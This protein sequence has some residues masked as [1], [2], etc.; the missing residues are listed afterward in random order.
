M[1]PR[2]VTQRRLLKRVRGLL[3][4]KDDGYVLILGMLVMFVML[5]MGGALLLQVQRNQQHVQRDRAYTQSLAVAEAGLNQYLW[6][7]ASGTSSEVN[8]FAIPGASAANPHKMSF[9][10][11][12]PYDGTVKGEYA[13]EITPPSASEPN[14]TVKVTGISNQ[15]VEQSRT[16]SAH[17]GRPAFSEYVLLADEQVRIGGPLNRKWY[18]KTH[19]NTGVCM[20]TEN[21]NDIISSART[22]YTYTQGGTYP[23][24]PGVWSNHGFGLTT[25]VPASSPSRNLWMWPVPKVDF[26]TVT[27]DFVKLNDLAQGTGVNIPYSTSAPHDGRQGW[28]IKLMPGEHYQIRQVTGEHED[29]N[30]SD[31]NDVGGYLTLNNGV[32]PH[33]VSNGTYDYP[34]D[35]VIFVHDNVWVEGEPHL[36][37]RITIA[38]SGQ[39]NPTG[40]TAAT[41][42]HII[43]DITYKEIDGTVVVGLIAQN[44]IEI[45]AYAPYRKGT[46]PQIGTVDMEINAAV[47]A[48]QGKEYTR[49]GEIGGPLRD[50]L[51]IYGSVS[52]FQTPYKYRSSG[53]GVGGFQNGSN[54]Y[55][56][57]LLHNPPPYFPTTGTYQIL[58]WQELSSSMAVEP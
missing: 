43:S 37:G 12:D 36:D 50:T 6:M 57:F 19:S 56:P 27:S 31:G 35:G 52:S 21:I 11:T 51:T 49:A 4:A 55:D 29:K 18:G 13:T 9:V 45:P 17:L 24:R 53:L 44:N 7:V 58:D 10:Y 32:Q 47:I 16:V 2:G 41:S 14:L 48:Q 34:E 26:S 22:T 20:E 30:Y 54:E 40:K 39:L 38:C 42:I 8:D 28:Y 5:L 1:A 15:P 46:K 3:L 33:G 23:G 25:V